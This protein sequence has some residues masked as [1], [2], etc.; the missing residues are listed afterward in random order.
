MKII[1]HYNQYGYYCGQDLADESPLEP[2]VFLIPAMATD[3]EPP[4]TKE[5]QL[6]R[7][8][9][10]Q[11]VIEDI[12]EAEPEPEPS[13]ETQIISPPIDQDTADMWEALFALSAELD[14][15]KG[16]N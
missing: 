12:P 3:K 5:N 2:G 11:W 8:V 1:Y 14:A 10:G 4:I 6:V 7:F 13:N 9:S 15:L 16:G